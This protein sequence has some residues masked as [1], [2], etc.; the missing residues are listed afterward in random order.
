M[1]LDLWRRRRVHNRCVRRQNKSGFKIPQS[2]NAR[3]VLFTKFS[4]SISSAF[5][6]RYSLPDANYDAMI[7]LIDAVA[8]MFMT[9][10]CCW[11]SPP[12]ADIGLTDCKTSAKLIPMLKEPSLRQDGTV[13][14]SGVDNIV[15]ALRIRTLL[16]HRSVR[17]LQR[18]LTVRN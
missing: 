8:M 7:S 18:V 11:T 6:T 2:D 1:E 17:E 13:T 10:R 9:Y 3:S 14:H 4:A 16:P 15:L 12:V 5:N